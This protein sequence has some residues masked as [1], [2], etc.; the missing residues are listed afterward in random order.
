VLTV[1]HDNCKITQTGWNFIKEQHF[2]LREKHK[3]GSSKLSYI[4]SLLTECARGA[5]KWQRGRRNLDYIKLSI[6]KLQNSFLHRCHDAHS[7]QFKQRRLARR[8]RSRLAFGSCSVQIQAGTLSIRLNGFSRT[9]QKN[10][11]ILPRLDHDQF[12]PNPLNI[13]YSSITHKFD[14]TGLQ[15]GILTASLN[16]PQR[17]YNLL[18]KICICFVHFLI[19]SRWVSL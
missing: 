2:K 16:V 13:H 8:Q 1:Y 19:L 17:T 18:I 10:S 7:A 4:A 14:A 5:T 12:L 9:L 6:E 15:S 3:T 11:R